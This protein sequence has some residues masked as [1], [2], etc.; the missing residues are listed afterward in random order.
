MLRLTAAC[1][2]TDRIA[3]LAS[4]LVRPAGIELTVLSMEPREVF[5]RIKWTREF[6]VGEMSLAQYALERTRDD[7]LVALPA[8][9]SRTFRHRAVYV[10]AGGR[11]G[12]PSDL[13]GGCIGVLEYQMSAAVWARGMLSDQFGLD[14]DSVEWVTGGL[15]DVGRRPLTALEVAGVRVRHETEQSLEAL[16]QAGAID[17]I[18][19]PQA[20]SGFERGDGTVRRLFDE[21]MVAERS[22]LESTGIFPIMHCVV[23]RRD[24]YERE[25][26]AARSLLDAF[27]QAR[28]NALDRLR[29]IEPLPIALPWI[30][31]SVRQT[32]EA[33]GTGSWWPYGVA[34]N[35]ATLDALSRYLQEQHLVSSPIEPASLFVP[36]VLDDEDLHAL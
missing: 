18:I 26:W 15:R 32:Q 34:A 33:F 29:R 27:D 16:L 21:P 3:D 9:T 2:V 5:R 25:R 31:E 30:E 11:I 35:R 12:H 23:L 8:F 22:Y 28:A 4:G 24:L 36:T 1:T 20:P 6:E 14:L 7:E 17:A 10:R 13:S 19:S